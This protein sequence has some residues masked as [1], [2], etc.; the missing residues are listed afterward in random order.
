MKQFKSRKFIFFS[1]IFISSII[2]LFVGLANFETWAEF[3]KWIF[4]AYII[5]NVAE[6]Y[7]NN[8]GNNG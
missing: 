2:A 1:I 7:T 6:H 8:K 4:S 3:M 5:G